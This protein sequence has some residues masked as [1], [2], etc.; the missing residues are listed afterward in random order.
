MSFSTAERA[1]EILRNV[2]SHREGL[3][4][5]CGKRSA[6]AASCGVLRRKKER[7][8]SPPRRLTLGSVTT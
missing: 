3:C 7:K 5:F 6:K 2:S 1:R 4:V 8:R